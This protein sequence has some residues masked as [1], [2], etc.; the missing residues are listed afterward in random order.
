MAQ[1]F[2]QFVPFQTTVRDHNTDQ[3]VSHH[4]HC[5]IN[6]CLIRMSIALMIVLNVNLFFTIINLNADQISNRQSGIKIL[7]NAFQRFAGE[8]L[9]P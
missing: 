5:Y 7:L 8:V 4:A 1:L 3:I 9:N 6:I 2:Q